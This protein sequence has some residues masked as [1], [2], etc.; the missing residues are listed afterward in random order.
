MRESYVLSAEY[1]ALLD[2][3]MR[4]WKAGRLRL[5]GAPGRPTR[6]PAADRHADLYKVVELDEPA[7]ACA[8]RMPD[9]EGGLSEATEL[10]GVLYE[11]GK[12][13]AV[14]ER[15]QVL[16]LA[17]GSLV[18]HP[19]GGGAVLLARAD[20][21]MVA[22]ETEYAVRLLTIAGANAG[23]THAYRPPGIAVKKYEVGV[24]VQ[25][26]VGAAVFMPMRITIVAGTHMA[27][28]EAVS[29]GQL[30][31]TL[32]ESG[33]R[34][35]GKQALRVQVVDGEAVGDEGLIYLEKSY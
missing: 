7:G 29:D 33:T 10:T 27:K 2:R 24:L 23:G 17:G 32:S 14:G 18:F 15:G 9:P 3:L 31:L 30:R 21:D 25:D 4:E 26:A 16:R 6:R 19:G 20:A 8:V 35:D 12:M 5:G 1:K 22:D 34:D 11:A 28:A 13:P